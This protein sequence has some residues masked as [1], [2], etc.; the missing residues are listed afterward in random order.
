LSFF[1]ELKRRNVFKVGIGYVLIAWLI[2]QVLQ[3]VFESFETPEWAIKAA[4]VLLATGL[5]F[6]LF[7]A[8]AF[9][10]TPEGIKRDHEVRRS[11]AITP[12]TIKQL[13]GA[14]KAGSTLNSMIYKSRCNGVADLELVD[15]IL[16]SSGRNNPENGITGVLVATETHFLQILEGNFETLNA[17]FERIARD[18]RHDTI[19]LI[20]FTEIDK[21]SFGDWAMH[22]I[23]L[24]NL[25]RE[26]E[27][28]LRSRFGEE[29]GSVRLP[30]TANE[31]RELL[32][33]LLPEDGP[34]P[35]GTA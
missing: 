17:T 11:Q 20:S 15:S 7:F 3:L 22:G 2:A 34:R 24:F 27:K 32:D 29:Q 9:E 26:L 10:M 28:S 30:T 25:N 6:A 33:T 18:T 5:P 31:V 4:L 21:R 8:W 14:A 23:G 1:N 19:Q 12:R 13:K 16:A 35:A